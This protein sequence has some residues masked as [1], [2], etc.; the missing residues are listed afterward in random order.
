MVSVSS[1][2]I[3]EEITADTKS[4]DSNKKRRSESNR[5]TDQAGAIDQPR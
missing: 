4:S 3:I 1:P 2:V 5:S